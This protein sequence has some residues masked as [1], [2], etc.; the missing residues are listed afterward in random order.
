M[1]RQADV[2][3]SEESVHPVAIFVS[4]GYMDYGLR[5]ALAKDTVAGKLSDWGALAT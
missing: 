1:V 3:Y 4:V 2:P 5:F